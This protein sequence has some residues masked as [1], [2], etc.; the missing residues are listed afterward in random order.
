DLSYVSSS[1]NNEMVSQQ[2]SNICLH[3]STHSTHIQSLT[4]Y[5]QGWW[6]DKFNQPVCHSL[7]NLIK[8]QKNLKSLSINEFWNTNY[9]IKYF[10]QFYQILLQ[11]ASNTLKCLQF[12]KLTH[13]PSFAPK[14]CSLLSSLPK[15][16]SLTITKFC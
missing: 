16:H 15:L 14:F 10:D 12:N 3:L 7:F 8:S 6:E 2:V 11:H 9:N 5:V 13:F 1:E 4:I